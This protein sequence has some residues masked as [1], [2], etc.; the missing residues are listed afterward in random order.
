MKKRYDLQDFSQC[1]YEDNV[2][3]AETCHVS[4][5]HHPSWVGMEQE[6][7]ELSKSVQSTVQQLTIEDIS[8]EKR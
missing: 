3:C 2:Y 8:N 7:E 5:P 6:K 4:C 1:L